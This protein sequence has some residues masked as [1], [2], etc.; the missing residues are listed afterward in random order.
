LTLT[1]ESHENR[2]KT[3]IEEKGDAD[4]P[5]LGRSSDEVELGMLAGFGRGHNNDTRRGGTGELA[6]RSSGTGVAE[7]E[8]RRDERG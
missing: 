1:D 7:L 5:Y 6:R 2:E 8:H 3:W 4:D